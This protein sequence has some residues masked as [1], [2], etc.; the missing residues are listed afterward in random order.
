MLFWILIG[1]FPAKKTLECLKK[2]V[3][4][5]TRHWCIFWVL[6]SALRCF[7]SI[8]SFIPF[9]SFCTT[10]L[11]LG[12]YNQHLSELTFKASVGLIKYSG[13]KIKNHDL[14]TKLLDKG[15]R[16]Y[17]T[18]YKILNKAQEF[19]ESGL[20]M[21]TSLNAGISNFTAQTFFQNASNTSLAAAA[22]AAT[23]ATA[24]TATT[25]APTAT[26]TAA[27][28]TIASTIAKG[29]N[30]LSSL[31]RTSSGDDQALSLDDIFD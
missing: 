25:A 26:A 21:L 29:S 7:D 4:G 1:T 17:K 18:N 3:K 24:P 11:L 13:T 8:L 31:M 30:A 20:A 2:P 23:A 15:R 16:F 12:N 27:V 14:T 19:L 6:Y 28:S 10:I 9:S 22:T 5:E